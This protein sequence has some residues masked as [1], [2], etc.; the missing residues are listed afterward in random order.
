MARTKK[1]TKKSTPRRSTRVKKKPITPEDLMAFKFISAPQIS[2][3]GRRVVMVHKILGGKNEAISNL[4]M[5]NADGSP[6]PSQF[7][8][9]GK[10]RHPRWSSDGSTIAFIGGREKHAPQI[11]TI[12]ANG[13][14]ATALTSFPEGTLMA[15]QWSP[16]GKSIAVSF[17]DQE[18]SWTQ[19]AIKA[20]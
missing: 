18:D 9:G 17:R 6:S 13:G 20:R 10:D 14:E 11:Y 7:T 4:Y 12:G 2:P 8:S 5:A 19:A 16:D 15:F 3:D 1:K